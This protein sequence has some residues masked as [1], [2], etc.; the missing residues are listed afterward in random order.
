MTRLRVVWY[1]KRY[2]RKSKY[3]YK[4]YYLSLPKALGDLLDARV[5]YAVRV[6]GPAIVYLPRGLESFFSRLEKLEKPHRENTPNESA[7]LTDSLREDSR[8]VRDND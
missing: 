5:E 1:W 2:M 8:T 6:F 3:H 4:R 7:L